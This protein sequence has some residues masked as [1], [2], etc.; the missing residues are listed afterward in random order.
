MARTRLVVLFGGPSSEH[1]VSIRSARSVL[2]AVDRD[3]YE[4]VAV[5]IRR[6]RQWRTGPVDSDLAAILEGGTPVHDMR[7]LR[8]DLC[9]PVLHGPFGEDGTIQGYLDALDVPHV[10]SGV[11]ASA[12]CMD[13]AAQKHLVAAAAPTVPLVPWF[14]LDL[15]RLDA[16]ALTRALQQAA[17]Q[18]DFPCFCKPANLGSSIGVTRCA[19]EASLR[20]A[21]EHASRFDRKLVLE[22]GVDAREIEVAVLGDGGPETITSAPGEI[23]LP[24]GIWYDYETKYEKDVATYHLP[25]A[26]PPELAT[27]IRRLALLAFRATGCEGLARVDFLLDRGT[28]TPYLNELNTMPG[29]TSISMY[30]KMMAQAGIGYTDLIDRLCQLGLA[31]HTA[32]RRLSATR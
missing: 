30:P 16:S 4:P 14:E 8:P 7:A 3:K 13:K 23:G 17:E 11:L 18:L 32:R 31:R 27:R 24:A 29:F 21:V 28:G 9:F 20:E 25:A 15:R 26:L 12:V 22:R 1:E 19:D 6:D 10:G 5:G 2:D